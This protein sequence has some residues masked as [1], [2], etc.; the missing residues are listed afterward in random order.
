LSVGPRLAG[1]SYVSPLPSFEAKN[2]QAKN[3]C[4]VILQD[5]RM[6]CHPLPRPCDI[7][8][9]LWTGKNQ[10]KEVEFK[11]AFDTKGTKTSVALPPPCAWPPK[12]PFMASL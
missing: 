4:C 6:A 8:W 2:H 9:E 7:L 5:T 3:Q 1:A 10:K 11:K 12:S